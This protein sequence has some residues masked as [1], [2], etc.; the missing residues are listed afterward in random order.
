MARHSHPDV[1]L[2]LVG[3][4]LAVLVAATERARHG[5]RTMVVN[6]GGP[7]GGY[8]G[9]VQ[10]DGRR[11]DAGMV[12]YEF[13]SFRQP[14]TPPALNSYDPLQR[15]DIGRFCEVVR[16]HV[17][18]RQVTR[19]VE[20][21]QMWIGGR[22][23]P[24]LLLA[25][26][27]AALPELPCAPAALAELTQRVDAA[28]H[29]PWHAS[30]KGA[31]LPD[32]WRAPGDNALLDCDSVS[33]L[34]HG[35]VL[36]EAVFAPFARQVLGRDAAHL[37][38]LYHRIPWLPLYWPET[39]LSWLQ[40]QPQRLP[41]TVFSYPHHGSVADLCD[42]MATEMRASPWVTVHQDRVA[43]VRRQTSGF[44]LQ[45]E[46]GGLIQ[47]ARL[48]WG[49][50]PCEGLQACGVA[51]DPPP[52]QRLPLLLAFIRLSRKALR[53]EFSVLHIADSASG[54]YRINNVS[55]CTGDN[56][57]DSVRLVVEANPV[58]FAAHHGAPSDDA[59]TER[60]VMNDLAGLGLIDGP[61]PPEFIR[62]LRMAGALPLPTADGLAAQAE[63]RALLRSRW[64]DVELFANS[65]GPFATSLSD[66]IVQGLLLA[67]TEGSS[68]QPSIDNDTRIH[69]CSH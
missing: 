2:T 45:L 4:S 9:G 53:R 67:H 35:S 1:P 10:A 7:W 69:A 55:R 32:G 65:A 14:A 22:L 11:W 5:L 68:E 16:D 12:M 42:Q 48:G 39:V 49:Q 15:N 40:G 54:A 8:F 46:Q 38:A 18:S 27:L 59:A 57:S 13:T 26:G 58:R 17:Q 66:Q 34:N 33:R 25:N 52:G 63:Q 51:A 19:T 31:W 41:D 64:P 36:H 60:C 23:L 21:P 50:T 30:R 24:D 6:T 28:R 44:T 43:T 56:D 47:T 61:Q 62:L 20:P 37:A 3:N 29:S